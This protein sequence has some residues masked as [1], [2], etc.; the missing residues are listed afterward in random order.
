MCIKSYYLKF[1]K[2]KV[3]IPRLEVLKNA[4]ICLISDD[5]SQTISSSIRTPWERIQNQLHI[6]IFSCK[7]QN[8]MLIISFHRSGFEHVLLLLI[9]LKI[10]KLFFY[11]S[12]FEHVLL[13]L[14]FLKIWKFDARKSVTSKLSVS[15]LSSFCWS[16]SWNKFSA[17]KSRTKICCENF[18]GHSGHIDL[19]S[20]TI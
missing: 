2:K 9:F 6:L 1:Y 11:L 17:K 12:G 13:L 19:K 10:R 14:I 20:K 5:S 3:I 16:S 4:N 18:Y 8:F 15:R 7:N